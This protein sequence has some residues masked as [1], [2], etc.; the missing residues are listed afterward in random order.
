MFFIKRAEGQQTIKPNS[1]WV[2]KI[3]SRLKN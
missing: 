2:P 1:P 3:E